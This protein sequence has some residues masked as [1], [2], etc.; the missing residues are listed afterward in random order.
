MRGT[1]TT[2]VFVGK[3]PS[4]KEKE[5][6]KISNVLQSL[7]SLIQVNLEGGNAEL[8]TTQKRKRGSIIKLNKSKPK[9]L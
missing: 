8:N 7:L 4:R 2:T 6:K 1:K 3:F 9:K 5:K